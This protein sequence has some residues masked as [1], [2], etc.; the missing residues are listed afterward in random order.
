LWI[1]LVLLL[2]E[3]FFSERKACRPKEISL[4]SIRQ[5]FDKIKHPARSLKPLK[6]SAKEPKFPLEPNDHIKVIKS[7]INTNRH[8]ISASLDFHNIEFQSV[9]WSGNSILHPGFFNLPLIRKTFYK[10]ISNSP[11]QDNYKIFKSPFTKHTKKLSEVKKSNKI[12]KRLMKITT[13]WTFQPINYITP[14]Y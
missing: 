6:P 13:P 10:S 12:L 1:V 14:K 8:N 11:D 5:K 3:E 7:K 2:M 4:D 9:K